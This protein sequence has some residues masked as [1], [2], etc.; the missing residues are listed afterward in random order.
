[1]SIFSTYY[2][3]FYPHEK[4]QYILKNEPERSCLRVYNN[5]SN[6]EQTNNNDDVSLKCIQDNNY[7]FLFRFVFY[8]SILHNTLFSKGLLIYV[9]HYNLY[10]SSY[11]KNVPQLAQLDTESSAKMKNQK[12]IHNSLSYQY[13]HFSKL[14]YEICFDFIFFE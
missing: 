6:G 8:Y 3:N 9:F 1:M 2:L 5:V 14:V 7:L 4:N 13:Q 10:N 12:E 11:L